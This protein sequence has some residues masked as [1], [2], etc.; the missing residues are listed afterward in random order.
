VVIASQSGHRLPA[1]TREQDKLL[2]L[3]PTEELLALPMLQPDTVT[4]PLQAY[5]LSK[6]ANSLRVMAEAVRWGKRR[7]TDQHDQP[8]HHHYATRKRRTDRAA[9]RW[10]SPYDR[11]IGG[12]EGGHAGRGRRRR[13]AADGP[14]GWI[15]QRQRLPHGWRGHGRLLVRRSRRGPGQA[16]RKARRHLR[17]Q[18]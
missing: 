10:V 3:T 7:G 2:A 9:G 4:D 11:G 8:W 14:G 16:M 18:L 13:G 15:H 1:L 17:R 12:R 5:Q 6:R